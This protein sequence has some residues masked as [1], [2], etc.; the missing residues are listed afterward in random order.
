[1]EAVTVVTPSKKR[2][3]SKTDAV[4]DADAQAQLQQSTLRFVSRL[5]T[6]PPRKHARNEDDVDDKL[7]DKTH[8]KV[9][10]AVIESETR[11]EKKRLK[12]RTRERARAL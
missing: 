10:L 3:P 2:T 11:V 6:L 9:E 5:S 8:V 4:V 1:M 12:T 7:D